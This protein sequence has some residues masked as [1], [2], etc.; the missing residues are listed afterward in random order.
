MNSS[1][2]SAVARALVRRRRPACARPR[3]ARTIEAQAGKQPGIG[4]DRVRAPGDDDIGPVADVAEGGGAHADGL[5]SRAAAAPSEGSITAP[6]ASAS[7]TAARWLSQSVS[8]RP[9]TS[10]SRASPRIAAAASTA[11]ATSTSRPST[12]AGRRRLGRPLGKPRVAKRAGAGRALERSRRPPR[13]RCR[14]IHIRSRHRSLRAQPS[15]RRRIPASGSGDPPAPA[16][17]TPR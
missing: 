10:G 13:P 15:A 17:R 5:R 11:S 1:A 9:H 3:R 2:S 7:A 16:T 14:R 4:G 6:I 12:R 8:P